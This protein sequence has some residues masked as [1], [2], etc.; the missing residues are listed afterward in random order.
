M[1]PTSVPPIEVTMAKIEQHLSRIV[2][3]LDAAVQFLDAHVG[4]HAPAYDA[5]SSLRDW[6][7]RFDA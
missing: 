4:N 7:R 6:R 2:L 5:R 3:V 1:M